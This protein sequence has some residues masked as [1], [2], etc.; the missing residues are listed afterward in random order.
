[1]LL[2]VISAREYDIYIDSKLTVKPSVVCIGAINE[3]ADAY[4]VANIFP[5]LTKITVLGKGNS[6]SAYIICQT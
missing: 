6:K 1:M 2:F 5:C 4:V 3:I